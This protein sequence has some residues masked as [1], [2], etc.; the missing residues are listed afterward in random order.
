[1]VFGMKGFAAAAVAVLAAGLVYVNALHNPYVYD[2]YRTILGNA[3]LTAPLDWRA[4]LLFDLSRP[5]TNISFAIDHAV[6]PSVPFGF[7]ATSVLLH[8]LNAALVFAVSWRLTDDGR[9][10]GALVPVNAVAFMTASLFAVHPLMTESVAYISSRS[11]VLAV[12]SLLSAFLLARRWMRRGGLA[13]WLAAMTFWLLGLATKETAVVWP[14]LLLGYELIFAERDGRARRILRLHLPIWI[15]AISVAAWRGALFVFGEHSGH[16]AI[17]WQALA[18]QLDAVRRYAK[19]VLVPAGQSIYYAPTPLHGPFDAGVIKS[20]ALI[21]ALLIGVWWLRKRLPGAAFGIV[22][23]LAGLA[24][25]AALYALGHGDVM[26]EHR[27]YFASIGA[28]L[29]LA[30]TLAWVTTLPGLSTRRLTWLYRLAFVAVLLSLSSR[31][32]VRNMVWSDPVNLW[33]E[34]VERTPRASLPNTVLG[35][36]LHA[37]GAHADAIEA[38]KRA[39]AIAP[40][41][42]SNY[43]KLATCLAELQRYDEAARAIDDL[44][45]VN[46]HSSLIPSGR[47]MVA[48]LSGRVD[49]A[50]TEFERGLA[51]G[52]N[53]VLALRWLAVLEEDY[54][55]RPAEAL[56]RC[57]ELSRYLPMDPANR[58]CLERNGGK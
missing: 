33:S 42:E 27:A 58:A 34:A 25:A 45:R 29:A 54:A 36:S 17:Q 5:L 28:F 1:V 53:D 8:M 7:H 40:G 49:A 46:A 38:Y 9:M 57:R 30:T 48:L 6:W 41:E 37:A 52:P 35:E 14:A 20:V 50:R 19:L 13:A 43:L 32:F 51:V 47:G 56:A 11:D 31:T 44:A 4:V 12:T 26:A 18:E 10:T 39:I 21:A 15:A 16:A 55:H 22:W 23:F 3:S 24:P 2:D